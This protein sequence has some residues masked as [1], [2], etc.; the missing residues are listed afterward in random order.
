MC[1]GSVDDL[2]AVNV[3]GS[4]LRLFQAGNNTQ[5]G[6]FSAAGRAEQRHEIAV[7][8][9]QVNVLQNMVFAVIFINMPQFNLA[10][11]RYTPSFLFLPVIV[12]V[13]GHQPPMLFARSA[14]PKMFAI[15]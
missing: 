13:S 14:S 9:R 5:R 4:A 10:H 3:N 11:N 6:C 15:A 7:F 8:D 12:L 1:L 2:L